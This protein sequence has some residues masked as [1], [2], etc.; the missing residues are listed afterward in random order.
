M[1][2]GALIAL[3]LAAATSALP[4][5]VFAQEAPPAYLADPGV[6]GVIFE[7]ERFRVIAAT[8]G[9]GEGDKPHSHPVP[10]VVYSLN[11]CTLKLTSASGETTIIHNKAGR[12]NAVP[13]TASHTAKNIGRAT[14]HVVFVEHK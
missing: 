6:Y 9:P 2:R 11:N 12:A 7:D 14:C 1:I 5:A 4:T 8:W 13:Y 10:S 3:G